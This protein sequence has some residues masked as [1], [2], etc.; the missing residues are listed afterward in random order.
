MHNFSFK[1]SPKITI[2]GEVMAD[3]SEISAHHTDFVNYVNT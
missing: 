3:Q 2:E 1:V